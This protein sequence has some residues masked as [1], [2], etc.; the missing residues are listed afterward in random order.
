MKKNYFTIFGTLVLCLLI[1]SCSHLDFCVPYYT[2]VVINVDLKKTIIVFP[3]EGSGKIEL[4]PGE[5][6][7]FETKNIPVKI[8]TSHYG[9][10]WT[11]KVDVYVMQTLFNGRNCDYNV[12]INFP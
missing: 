10:N 4:K 6:C 9:I 8:Y 7:F 2:G 1:N 5:Y 11:D 12:R 3:P